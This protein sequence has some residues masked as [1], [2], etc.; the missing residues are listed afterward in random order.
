M[1]TNK[2]KIA[3]AIIGA[4][5]M[6][7][8]ATSAQ[9]GQ[10]ASVQLGMSDVTDLDAGSVVIG[11]FGMPMAAVHEYFSVE[12]EV[13]KALGKPSKDFGG[14]WEVE[15]DYWTIAGYGVLAYPVSD[16]FTVRGRVGVLYESIEVKAT[17]PLG[18]GTASDT[19]TGLSFGVGGTFA[20]SPS[21]NIIAEY[22]QIE[23][24][25]THLSAGVQFKF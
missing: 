15:A 19:D 1:N 14:G 5:A 9:A 16:A 25:V 23:S 2:N 24:D 10:Y 13:T 3:A 8:V 6:A 17:T 22:T 21:M 12:G 20:I 7:G 4:I 11:T 18:S